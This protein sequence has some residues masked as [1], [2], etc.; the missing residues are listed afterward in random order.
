MPWINRQLGS[1]DP[2]L[3]APR[4]SR[5]LIMTEMI[6]DIDFAIE[7]LPVVSAEASAPYRLTK[8]A[9]LALKSNWTSVR[10]SVLEDWL[11]GV[12]KNGSLKKSSNRSKP[13]C[14]LAGVNNINDSSFYCGSCLLQ[15]LFEMF[16][17]LW[18]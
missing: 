11:K 17:L 7:A 13:E 16:Y 5:E 9:A 18:L 1:D 12:L 2:Q 4:D 8:G 6:K 10:I 14:L 3:Y 15:Q